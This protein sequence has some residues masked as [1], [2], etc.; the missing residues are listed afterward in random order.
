M[1]FHFLVVFHIYHSMFLKFFFYILFMN[2]LSLNN[3][4]SLFLCL[5]FVNVS[6]IIYIFKNFL[7]DFYLFS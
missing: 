2:I 4:Y 1:L 3:I 7:I 5:P 6:T